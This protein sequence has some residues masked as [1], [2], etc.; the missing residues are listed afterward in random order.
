M[1]HLKSRCPAVNAEA[2]CWHQN[3]LRGGVISAY[4]LTAAP[5]PNPPNAHFW[6]VVIMEYF[7]TMGLARKVGLGQSPWPRC[8]IFPVD[9]EPLRR[10]LD[11]PHHILRPDVAVIQWNTVGYLNKGW[12][13]CANAITWNGHT[14]NASR[15]HRTHSYSS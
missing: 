6:P 11:L 14:T 8:R 7:R 12:S 9:E 10:V 3:L 4:A 13:T 5:W 2:N 15:T 1:I